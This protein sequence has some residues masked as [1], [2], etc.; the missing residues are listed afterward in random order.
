MFGFVLLSILLLASIALFFLTNAVPAI[1]LNSLLLAFVYGQFGLLAHDFGHSQVFRKQKWNDFFGHIAGAVVGLSYSWWKEKHNAHH[2]H[3]NFEDC[4]PDIDI[5]FLAYSEKQAMEARGIARFVIRHQR[6]FFF[7]I[8]LLA[9]V[10]LRSSSAI[11][12]L[13][14]RQRAD[15]ALNLFLMS[16]H[17]AAYLGIIFGTQPWWLAILFVVVHQKLWSAYITSIFAPNHKGMPVL[18][19]RST[20]F[21]REQILTARNIRPGVFTNLYYGHL[22]MQIEHHLFPHL[23]R[24]NSMQA[25]QIVKEFCSEKH[26]HYHETSILGSY[27]EILQH[28]R[29]VSLGMR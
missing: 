10:S 1:M 13:R 14:E 25:R 16:L 4:D 3:T 6:L 2:A 21:L 23:P 15:F 29:M 28:L 19:G 22:N 11:F 5:P 9:W 24:H 27:A 20:D 18:Q 12:T 17:A 26:I 8:Q 7:P